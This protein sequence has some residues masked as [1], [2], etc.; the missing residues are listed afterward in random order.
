MGTLVTLHQDGKTSAT[1]TPT[2]DF[3]SAPPCNEARDGWAYFVVPLAGGGEWK[4]TG[5]AITTVNSIS[6]GFDSWG[7]PPLD[8]WIDGLAFK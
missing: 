7:A 1:F 8:V 3:L 4:R 2:R 6:L 5:G